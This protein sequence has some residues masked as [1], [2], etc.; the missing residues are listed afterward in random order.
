M[1]KHV[2]CFKLKDRSKESCEKAK[3]ILMSM[4]NR[5]SLLREIKVGVDELHT[6]RSYD[7]ILETIFENFEDYEQYQNDPYHVEVVKKYM[8]EV[9]EDSI[10]ID[11]LI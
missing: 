9:R 1:V 6:S 11:Y 10:A 3:E 5:I 8:H 7:L 4:Q 2:V